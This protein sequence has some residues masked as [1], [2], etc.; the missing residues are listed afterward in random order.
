M[1]KNILVLVTIILGLHLATGQ[2]KMT[3]SNA[4]VSFV[5]LSK[6]VK[7]SISGFSSTSEIDTIDFSKS[8]LKGSVKVETLETGNFVRNW[9]LKGGKYFNADQYPTLE[10][11]STSITKTNDKYKVSGQLTIKET[12][13][14]ISFLFTK[15]GNR[16]KGTATI[17]SSDFGVQI[18]KKSREDN[19]VAITLSFELK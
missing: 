9:S 12:T 15:E 18:I 5:F 17:Y 19:K 11:E 10:F 8:K 14:P 16:L 13:K 1:K 2:D 4:E 3:L 7:G 6:K